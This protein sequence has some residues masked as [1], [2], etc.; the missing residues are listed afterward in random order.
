MNTIIRLLFLLPISL[1]AVAAQELFQA[2]QLEQAGQIET[3]FKLYLQALEKNPEQGPAIAGLVRTGVILKKFDTLLVVLERLK[4]VARNQL[5]IEL[6]IIEALFGLRRRSEAI[7]R[8]ERL[9]RSAPDRV[10]AAADLLIRVHEYALA[11]RYL[12]P[13]VTNRFNP[14]LTDRLLTLYEQMGR[15]NAAAT[16]I[17]QLVNTDTSLQSDVTRYILQNLDRLRI[18]GRKAGR[19]NLL[20][21]L[22]KIRNP[23]LRVR[24][25]TQL[26]LGADR[27][28]DAARELLN[29]HQAGILSGTELHQ[30]AREWEQAGQYQAALIIY[31]QLGRLADA[32]R[33]L[34]FQGKTETALK[35]LHS[36][37]TPDGLFEYAELLRQEKN[38]FRTAA[39]VYRRLLRL[40]PNDRNAQLG[41]V[42]AFIGS[43]QLDS[44]RNFIE[45]LNPPDDRV[46]FLRAKILF[47]QE[48]F[49]SLAPVIE[50]FSRR[51][52]DSPLFNDLLELNILTLSSSRRE[53]AAIMFTLETGNYQEAY[54]QAA[55][56]RSGD[57]LTAQ[58]ALIITSEIF[59]RQHQYQSAI[60]VLDTLIKI[61]PKG[62]LAPAALF[63]QLEICQTGLNDTDRAQR[64][65]EQLI[66]EYPT[67]LYAPLARQRINR[68]SSIPSGTLH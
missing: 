23:L 15:F 24:A 64:I 58:Q 59:S 60:A 18:W 42:A 30:L 52:G 55:R 4:P 17:V 68:E 13:Q 35:L 41:L 16:L 12:E 43:G 45:Q 53:L 66:Q 34:R 67:S 38:D 6:G 36:D 31:Q 9:L 61:F 32:A 19:Q 22:D 47:Y 5:D 27:E 8:L 49:D 7:S 26:L 21:E 37:T 11:T 62:E 51:Y 20:A 1:S 3:A 29:A 2:Q 48:K 65:A 44:A 40:R 54:R 10:M 63:R 46:L 33:T 50:E 28:N 56:L 57:E 14:Q 25:R 39:A